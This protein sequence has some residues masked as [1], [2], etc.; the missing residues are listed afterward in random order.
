ME[1]VSKLLA[2]RLA[3]AAYA[4][5]YPG[6]ELQAQYIHDRILDLAPD[7]AFS[8]H[9]RCADRHSGDFAI[10]AM[11]IVHVSLRPKHI[12]AM[13]PFRP[14]DCSRKSEISCSSTVRHNGHSV[15]S[16]V[17]YLRLPI[18]SY[19]RRY[20]HLRQSL[21]FGSIKAR[22][23]T[24][25]SSRLHGRDRGMTHTAA[26]L[27]AIMLH[28]Q[29]KSE[30]SSVPAITSNVSLMRSFHIPK[31]P[32]SVSSY[33][34]GTISAAT[35]PSA[36]ASS[37]L[38]V[39]ASWQS[40]PRMRLQINMRPGSTDTSWEMKRTR[41]LASRSRANMRAMAVDS[42]FSSSIVNSQERAPHQL[43]RVSTA[44]RSGA[45]ARAIGP[46]RI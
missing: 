27:M 39:A 12:S 2:A 15:I 43:H 31:R 46:D 1:P 16:T 28:N 26:P 3:A 5:P 22:S 14:R 19:A 7:A 10:P 11:R 34:T 40:T 33:T 30:I 9:H 20:S 25:S 17:G 38:C 13:G 6:T 42:T 32:R 35:S 37:L 18:R 21:I 44:V 4:V 36:S 29:G 41:E 45:R 24:A 23:R 8:E